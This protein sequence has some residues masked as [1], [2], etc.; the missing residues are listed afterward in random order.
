MILK[1]L[2][3]FM[4]W[5]KKDKLSKSQQMHLEI[6]EETSTLS[7]KDKLQLVRFLKFPSPKQA[8]AKYSAL[9]I[10]TSK[11]SISVNFATQLSVLNACFL[12]ITGMNLLN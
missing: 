2:K 9:S 1:L 7:T 6:W 3:T 8:L 10:K 5:F 4:K 12:T 11:L